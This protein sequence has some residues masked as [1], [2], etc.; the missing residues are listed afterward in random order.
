MKSEDDRTEIEGAPDRES[1]AR[2][3]DE[4]VR[5]IG[6][7]ADRRAEPTAGSGAAAICASKKTR[8]R[9]R[10]IDPV[11]RAAI[12]CVMRVNRSRQLSFP[13]QNSP[14]AKPA[15][16]KSS[17]VETVL[18]R[19]GGRETE[20]LLRGDLHRFAG[21]RVAAFARCRRRHLELAESADRHFIAVDCGIGDRGDDRVDGLLAFGLR[22][23]ERGCNA[24]RK[25]GL[26]RL[27]VS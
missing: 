8:I 11:G 15:G 9:A 27:I 12:I 3:G 5:A 24:V 14:P 17:A 23:S 4:G 20:L 10:S 21:C 22:K 7:F 13:H 19:L 25:F 26:V 18:Y 2:R 1:P 16:R 6:A